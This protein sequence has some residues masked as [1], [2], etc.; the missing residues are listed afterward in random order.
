MDGA[1][2]AVE[3]DVFRAQELVGL[4]HSF[5]YLPAVGVLIG[6]VSGNILVVTC[7]MLRVTRVIL[8]Y[9]M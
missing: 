2:A 9:C 6:V 3:L 8:Q 4:V 5:E 1:G 7:V